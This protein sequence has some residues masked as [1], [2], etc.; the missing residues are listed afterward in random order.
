MNHFEGT[1]TAHMAARPMDV[2]RLVTDLDR[3]PEWNH[4]IAAVLDTP[5]ALVPG[6]EWTVRMDVPIIGHWRSRSTLAQL[7]PDR[8]V[9]SYTSKRVD[10]NPTHGNWTWQVTPVDDGTRVDVRWEGH[11]KTLV[12][13]VVAA[14]IRSRQLHREVAHS[15]QTLAGLAILRPA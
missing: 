2:F 15:L 6:S 10:N 11:P 1:A 4:C 7:D 14:P 8:L 9:F 12:R 3:L 5:A 13:K